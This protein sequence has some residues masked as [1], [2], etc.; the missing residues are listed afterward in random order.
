MKVSDI[1][2][3][4]VDWM[5]RFGNDPELKFILKNGHSDLPY[6][7]FRWVQYGSLYYAEQ[8][9]EVAYLAQAHRD[10]AGFGGSVY[11]LRMADSWQRGQDWQGLA[12]SQNAEGWMVRP[13]GCRWHPEQQVV[14]LRGPWHCGASR[15][16]RQVKPILD[17]AVLKNEYNNMLRSPDY[18]R[19]MGKQGRAWDGTY[20]L[21]AFTLDFVRE[22][23]DKLAP[24]LDLYEGDYGWYPIYRGMEP[25]NP[26][27]GRVPS[28]FFNEAS[29]A[30]A[31]IIE[32]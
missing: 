5:E 32:C 3:V 22:V 1:S 24:W 21:K 6:D 18:Y 14:E 31:R 15:V 29:D 20:C 30:Q 13:C 8:E 10:H 11:R 23:V 2:R 19:R 16:S 17:V 4:K 9:N 12:L 26:R 7:Q 25:K 28:V 27:K